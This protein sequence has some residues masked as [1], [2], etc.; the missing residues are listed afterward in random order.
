MTEVVLDDEWNRE[1]KRISALN[2]VSGPNATYE[3]LIQL[4]VLKERE[5]PHELFTAAQYDAYKAAT[6]WYNRFKFK[7][8][9]PNPL[10]SIANFI[11]HLN[12]LYS[13]DIAFNNWLATFTT[14]AQAEGYDIYNPELAPDKRRKPTDPAKVARAQEAERAREALEAL[15]R[16]KVEAEQH[17]SK[18][19]SE[20][21]KRMMEIV[22]ARNS[23]L[24]GLRADIYE[25]E[26]AYRS[27]KAVI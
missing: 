12:P 13:Y 14:W 27:A 8:N 16:N 24:N 18:L 19:T 20:A 7:T 26:V 4:L 9:P 15:R 5:N 1:A 25:A 6:A 3:D 17:Y 10:P 22:E 23:V 11:L 2:V 21:Q